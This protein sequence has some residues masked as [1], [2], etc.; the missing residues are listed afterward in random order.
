MG[1]TDVTPH[2]GEAGTGASRRTV[3]K[4]F[5]WSVP[6]VAAAI[7]APIS[8]ASTGCGT[9][10][11]SFGTTAPGVHDRWIPK[12]ATRIR[13]IVRAGGGAATGKSGNPRYAGA[14][15]TGEFVLPAAWAG[16]TLRLVVGAGGEAVFGGLARGGIGFGRGG[17]G[18]DLTKNDGTSAWSLAG[19]G[20]SAILIGGTPLVVAGGGGGGPVA[21]QKSQN[22]TQIVEAQAVFAPH[23]GSGFPF[24]KA[25]HFEPNAVG[26]GVKKAG[27]VTPAA[28]IAPARGGANGGA[29]VSGR[30]ITSSTDN[31]SA[32]ASFAGGSGAA[33]GSGLNGGGNGGNG[34]APQYYTLPG[35]TVG[36]DVSPSGGGGGGGYHGGGG[37][38]FAFFRENITN[39]PR[40]VAAASGGG[41]GSSFLASRVA[42]ITVRGDIGVFTDGADTNPGHQGRVW[43]SWS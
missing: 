20:G 5:A 29:G 19:G 12:C 23:A 11:G 18:T 8:S 26:F 13:Y 3:V 16:G 14:E 42:G 28:L 39:T 10:A 43:I 32:A 1:T 33:L 2:D 27:A 36:A 30:W 17:N 22:G 35:E 24:G 40:P 34:A 9:N 37:G 31:F 38:G 15:I 4:G 7:A 41:A 25:N 21:L 6:A